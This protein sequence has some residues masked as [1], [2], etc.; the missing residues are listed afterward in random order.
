MP[1][2]KLPTLWA[3]GHDRTSN[4]KRRPGPQSILQS[5]NSNLRFCFLVCVLCD[6]PMGDL[7]RITPAPKTAL[8]SAK[9]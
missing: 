8:Q 6:K 2:K 4:V 9:N 5:A 3:K 1:I 7:K